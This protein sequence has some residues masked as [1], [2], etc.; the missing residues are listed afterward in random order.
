M[1]DKNNRKMMN[2]HKKL[3]LN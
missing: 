3:M 2:Y 1:T